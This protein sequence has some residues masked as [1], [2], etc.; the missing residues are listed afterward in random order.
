MPLITLHL[1]GHSKNGNECSPDRTGPST[2]MSIDFKKHTAQV[3]LCE[4][5]F[6]EIDSDVLETFYFTCKLN[7]FLSV[8]SVFSSK[9]TES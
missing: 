3:S 2:S 9:S 6:V 7:W 8:S 5:Q 1:E 4:D